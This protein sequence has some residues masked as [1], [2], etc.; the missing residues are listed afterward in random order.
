MRKKLSYICLAGILPFLFCFQCTAQNA[1]IDSL[2]KLLLTVRDVKQRIDIRNSIA[3]QL[4]ICDPTK[5]KL[6]ALGVLTDALKINYYD[7]I[8][9][10]SNSIGISYNDNGRID[11]ALYYLNQNL[12]IKDKIAPATYANTLK[13]I[14][15]VYFD[16]SKYDT[17]K[18]F[19][20]Q[21]LELCLD[22]NL[23]KNLAYVYNDLANIDYYQGYKD[24]SMIYFGKAIPVLEELNDLQLP[25][26]YSNE[27]TVLREMKPKDPQVFI[28]LS[29]GIAAADKINNKEAKSACVGNLGL[30]YYEDKNYGQALKYFQQAI[31]IDLANNFKHSLLTD[32]YN[33]GNVYLKLPNTDSATQ[34]FN[35]SISTAREVNDSSDLYAAY[36]GLAET[37]NLKGDV[38]NAYKLLMDGKTNF[39]KTEDA[40]NDQRWE[41]AIAQSLT[42]QRKYDEATPH[43]MRSLQLADTLKNNEEVEDSY[44]AMYKMYENSGNSK[45]A[46]DYFKKYTTLKD[47]L[48]GN[49]LAGQLKGM[50]V[51][52]ETQKKEDSLILQSKVVALN[53]AEI[54][55]QSIQLYILIPLTIL[56]LAGGIIIFRL[57][58]K[59]EHN[60]QL[61][62]RLKN[63]V[64]HDVKN[65]FQE[66]LAFL[67]IAKKHNDDFSIDEA[68]SRISSMAKVHELLYK[69]QDTA[70]LSLQPYLEEICKEIKNT[71]GYQDIE[72]TVNAPVHLAMDIS[73][74]IGWIVNEL[75]VNAFKYAF[76]ETEK[77]KIEITI[78]K[79]ANKYFLQV[80]DNGKGINIATAT[81]KGFGYTLIAGWAEELG[82]KY[83]MKN[84]S[85]T[86]FEMIFQ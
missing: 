30:L 49:E 25:I 32:Y 12:L 47:S 8:G 77:G 84:D 75:V 82:A 65:Q 86:K 73:N 43:F 5:V 9:R 54:K 16:Q 48:E 37:E 27:A 10:A 79:N 78:A 7:G 80:N 66:I 33:T 24:S 74:K 36:I 13:N 60:R 31:D 11:S 44:Q 15:L 21:D 69:S 41:F 34:F 62:E 23:K 38:I 71:F 59:A 64:H 52:Y 63:A 70:K 17:S 72:M 3:N 68:S 2:N 1:K 42:G 58:H 26:T 45:Q 85:G 18:L 46:F 28:L 53:K 56:L 14:G 67:K 20:L 19:Y 22:K 51:K 50:E 57:Y 35:S 83:S 81:A 4:I 40:G 29:K 61:I 39:R 55:S 6:Y 76:E